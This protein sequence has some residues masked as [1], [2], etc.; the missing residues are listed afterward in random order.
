MMQVRA[1]AADWGEIDGPMLVFG[2]VCSNLHALEALEGEAARLH[3]PPRNWVCTGDAVA[4][5]AHPGPVVA[6]LRALGVRMIAGN[7]ERQL[8]AQSA[9]CGCGFDGGS[10]CDLMSARWFAHASAAMT[11][12]DRAWMADLP[13][14]AVIRHR[15]LRYGVIH[16][17][18]RQVNRFL[19]PVTP[20]RDLEAELDALDADLGP[21]AGRFDAALTGHSGIAFVRR[22]GAR[23]WLNAG[24]LGMP[25]HDGTPQTEYALLSGDGRLSL[26]RLS[27]DHVAAAW[28]MRDAGLP[29]GYAD[30][31]ITG[32]WPNEDI[33]PPALRL[34]PAP[35]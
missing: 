8:A 16:G 6:R 23:M 20:T 18:A 11:P 26:R 15:G 22:L 12:A 31:L 17:G 13:D 25:P 35:T 19:W 29:E 1:A 28:D 2:G 32:F 24:T 4:Y 10:A 14:R 30:A 21:L 34:P 3:V 5:C 9:D 7:V 27:Y 33:L